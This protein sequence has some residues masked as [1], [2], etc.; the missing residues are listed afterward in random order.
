MTS[1]ICLILLT[2]ELCSNGAVNKK[3]DRSVD[4]ECKMVCAGQ[5][6]VPC[7]PHKPFATSAGK[8]VNE[9]NLSI[10]ARLLLE[11]IDT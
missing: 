6:Q 1:L 10:K 5:T 3:V 4:D 11:Y 8:Y 2:F 7:W 9:S